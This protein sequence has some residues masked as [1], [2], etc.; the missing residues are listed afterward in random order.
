MMPDSK[1]RILHVIHRLDRGGVETWLVHLLRHIDRTR[2][3]FDFLVHSPEPGAYDDEVRQ[4]GANIYPCLSPSRP[5]S[6]ARSFRQILRNH[7]PYDVVHSH[8]QMFGGA[9]MRLAAT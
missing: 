6:Y 7:G 8:V 4:M 1:V 5:L 9:I 3:A 2:F